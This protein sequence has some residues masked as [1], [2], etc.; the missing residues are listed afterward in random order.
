MNDIRLA[1]LPSLARVATHSER[2]DFVETVEVVLGAK[3]VNGIPQ[4]AIQFLHGGIRGDAGFRRCYRL[5][6][7]R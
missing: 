5:R 1:G 2:E 4:S 3:G 6:R 7:V